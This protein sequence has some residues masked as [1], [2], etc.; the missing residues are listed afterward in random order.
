MTLSEQHRHFVMKGGTSKE[1]Q[2]GY[3]DASST[4]LTRRK[5]VNASFIYDF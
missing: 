2:V 1:K 3:I 4:A 5:I